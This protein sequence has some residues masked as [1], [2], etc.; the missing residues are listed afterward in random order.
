MSDPAVTWQAVQAVAEALQAITV[1]NGYRT[2]AGNSVLVEQVQADP[3]RGAVER[4]S[5]Y[6]DRVA[7]TPASL[8]GMADWV[9]Q[10]IVDAD[11]PSNRADAQQ[12]AHA[13]MADVFARFPPGGVLLFIDAGVVDVEAQTAEFLTRVDGSN[14]SVA[15]IR[16]QATLRLNP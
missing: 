10:L 13:V 4:L 7:R 16:L 9:L 1:A 6:L 15:Q 14:A 2:N 11:V 8:D 5:V 3:A 12:Q